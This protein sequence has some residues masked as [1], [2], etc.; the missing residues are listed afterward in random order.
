MFQHARLMSYSL[1]L[2]L[3]LHSSVFSQGKALKNIAIENLDGTITKLSQYLEKGPVY[4]TFWALWCSPCKAELRALKSFA[5]EHEKD[6]FTI[7]AINQDSPKSLA[8]VKAYIT[9]QGYPFVVA[10]DPNT[11][12]FQAL[13]GQNLP[14]SV[15]IDRNGKVVSTRTGYLAGDEKEIADDILKLIARSK[16]E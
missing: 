11:Q 5:I 8:K 6:P 4:M 14:F 10:I 3:L 13:N 16:D 9:S 2:S 1:L 7:L 12:V 15:L